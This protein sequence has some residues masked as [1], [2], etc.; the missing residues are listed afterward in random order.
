M[1][2]MMELKFVD[3]VIC[4]EHRCFML[5]PHVRGGLWAGR[6]WGGGG[7]RP[8]CLVGLVLRPTDNTDMG[9]EVVTQDFP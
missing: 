5:I 2:L 9:A 8:W 1:K 7:G 6:G 3:D 4:S